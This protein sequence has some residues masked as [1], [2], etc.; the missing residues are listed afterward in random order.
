MNRGLPDSHLSKIN[1]TFGFRSDMNININ[2]KIE[3]IQIINIRIKYG[4]TKVLVLT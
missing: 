2:I 4:L 3:Y 1:I